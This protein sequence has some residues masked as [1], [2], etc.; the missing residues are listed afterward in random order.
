MQALASTYVEEGFIAGNSIVMLQCPFICMNQ[1]FLGLDNI[2]TIFQH[3]IPLV[4][5]ISTVLSTG[6]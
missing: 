4:V 1:D 2:I 6:A 5:S 3:L